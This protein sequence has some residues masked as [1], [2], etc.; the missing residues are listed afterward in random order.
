[1]V[2]VVLLELVW[3]TPMIEEELEVT[4]RVHCWN[5]GHLRDPLIVSR[6][7]HRGKVAE[8]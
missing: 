6:D 3:V 5:G 7:L 1:M 4:W 8:S 2:A